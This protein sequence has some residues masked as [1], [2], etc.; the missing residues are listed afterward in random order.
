[1]RF[2]GRAYDAARP[3]VRP[4][5]IQRVYKCARAHGGAAGGVPII[6]TLKRVNEGQV[7]I[8]GVDRTNL[9]GVET[10]QI[11][12]RQILEEAYRVVSEAGLEVTDEISAVE[13]IRGKVVVVPNEEPN[14]KITYSPDLA[15]L[16]LRWASNRARKV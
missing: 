13:K 6:D 4:E 3:L 11:F 2:R 12:R 8:G 7:V 10:P 15:R 5:L 16:K 1:M 14:F 9:F